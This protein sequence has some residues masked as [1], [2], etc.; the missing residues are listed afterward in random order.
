MYMDVELTTARLILRPLKTVDTVP[1][2]TI[3]TDPEVM[4]YMGG[5]QSA[6]QS[7]WALRAVAGSW[8][9]DGF[10][11]FAVLERESGRWVGWAGPIKPDEWPTPEIGWAIIRECWG[12]GYAT[13]AAA[14]TIDWGFRC[15]PW[16]EIVHYILPGNTKSCRVAEKL[17]SSCRGLFRLPSTSSAPPYTVEAWGQSREQW[18][19]KGTHSAI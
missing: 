4:E 9:L 1:W 7:W 2:A 13:E 18:L 10:S 15:F 17:G 16:E 6:C 19:S 5:V 8:Y 12:Q 11:R 3:R 14:A